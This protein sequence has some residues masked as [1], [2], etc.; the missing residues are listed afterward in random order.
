MFGRLLT[1]RMPP[2]T[3]EL[4]RMGLPGVLHSEYAGNN[5]ALTIMLSWSGQ[6]RRDLTSISLVGVSPCFCDWTTVS[7]QRM[8]VAMPRLPQLVQ[9]TDWAGDRE[10]NLHLESSQR[11]RRRFQALPQRAA[12]ATGLRKCAGDPWTVALNDWCRECK[13]RCPESCAVFMS[14]CD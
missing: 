9:F 11:L 3:A 6:K 4:A 8:M 7:S 14:V 5:V 12:G 2:S 10:L 1:Y 13:A